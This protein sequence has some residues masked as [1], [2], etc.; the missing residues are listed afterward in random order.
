MADQ[1]FCWI[2]G[3]VGL[4][5]CQRPTGNVVAE[6]RAVG[7]LATSGAPSGTSSWQRCHQPKSC[8]LATCRD[9]PG[10]H[11]GD[12]FKMFGA[13]LHCA[14]VFA[15]NYFVR[16]VFEFQCFCPLCHFLDVC[17]YDCS[18]DCGRSDEHTLCE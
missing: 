3:Q 13:A 7:F 1:D 9:G 15:M 5:W 10:T 2:A 6:R 17:L 4:S 18:G 12:D 14:D 8:A 11:Q 16:M